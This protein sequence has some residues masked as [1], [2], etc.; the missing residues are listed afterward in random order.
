MTTCVY[1]GINKDAGTVLHNS[2][3]PTAVTGNFWTSKLDAAEL[4]SALLSVFV[5]Y[6]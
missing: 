6:L 5:L 3:E 1:F 4:K 2:K